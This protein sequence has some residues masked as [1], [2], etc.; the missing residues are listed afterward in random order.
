MKPPVVQLT[1]MELATIMEEAKVRQIMADEQ[2]KVVTVDYF[3]ARDAW[4]FPRAFMWRFSML[5]S[6]QKKP[7]KLSKRKKLLIVERVNNAVIFRS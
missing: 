3:P 5:Q 2:R 1:I 7:L 4:A 6:M